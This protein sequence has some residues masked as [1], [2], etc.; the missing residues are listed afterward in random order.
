VYACCEYWRQAV[1]EL[2]TAF[3]DLRRQTALAAAQHT[4]DFGM[5]GFYLK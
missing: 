3:F 4:T 1:K 2:L 5:E